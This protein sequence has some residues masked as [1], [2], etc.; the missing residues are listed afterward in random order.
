MRVQA[1]SYT[2]QIRPEMQRVFTLLLW[3]ALL[4][5]LHGNR[6]TPYGILKTV[7]CNIKL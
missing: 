2:Y 7:F 3:A 4:L 1:D 5:S 6:P